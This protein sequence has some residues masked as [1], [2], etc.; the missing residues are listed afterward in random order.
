MHYHNFLKTIIHVHVWFILTLK[1]KLLFD[2]WQVNIWSFFLFYLYLRLATRPRLEQEMDSEYVPDGRLLDI[3][4]DAWR[5]DKLPHDDIAV[6]Q[7]SHNARFI[8]YMYFLRMW[9]RCKFNNTT[10]FWLWIGKIVE[11]HS[12]AAIY[13]LRICDVNICIAFAFA[14]LREVW[15][16]L[17][18]QQLFI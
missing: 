15:T 14:F 5:K 9:M 13:S 17:E 3:V 1:T 16:R 6:P 18:S 11:L 12:T 7:A 4:D 2:F 8:Q 10:S